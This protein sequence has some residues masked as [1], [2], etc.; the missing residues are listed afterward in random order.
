[1]QVWTV[2]SLESRLE[3]WCPWDDGRT[4]KVSKKLVVIAVEIQLQSD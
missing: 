1:M 4:L 2:D 3:N